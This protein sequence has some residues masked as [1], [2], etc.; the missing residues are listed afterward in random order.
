LLLPVILCDAYI[1]TV[2]YEPFSLLAIVLVLSNDLE[3]VGPAK[4]YEI[5]LGTPGKADFIAVSPGWYHCFGIEDAIFYSLH[6]SV[7]AKFTSQRCELGLLVGCDGTNVGKK[8][9]IF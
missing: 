7:N 6:N 4:T 2:Y 8:T 9:T 1:K 5:L 3:V